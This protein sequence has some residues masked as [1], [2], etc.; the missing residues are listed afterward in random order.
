MGP[1]IFFFYGGHI[2]FFE[3]LTCFLEMTYAILETAHA[4]S[5]FSERH[6]SFWKRYAILEL[7]HA[8][9]HFLMPL[10]RT[11]YTVLE[12]AYA[13]SERHMP[14]TSKMPLFGMAYANLGMAYAILERHMSDT[15]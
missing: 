1:Q 4:K 11:A 5:H 9:C 10:F 6:M 3:S 2:A 7:S 12:T 14:G 15:Y 13:I 8:K